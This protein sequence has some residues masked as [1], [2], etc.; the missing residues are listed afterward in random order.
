[1]FKPARLP[2]APMWGRAAG[3]T[4]FGFDTHQAA[5]MAASCAVMIVTAAGADRDTAII[6]GFRC[7]L[8][9]THA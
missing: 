1:M 7:Q 9:V 8:Q 4:K 5:A 6:F 2:L 3:A